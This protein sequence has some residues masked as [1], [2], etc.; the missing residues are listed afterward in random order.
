MGEEL[1]WTSLLEDIHEKYIVSTRKDGGHPWS[2]GKCK[3]K[4][5]GEWGSNSSGRI[6]V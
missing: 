5:H 4:P 2:L 1:G 3:P 6:P